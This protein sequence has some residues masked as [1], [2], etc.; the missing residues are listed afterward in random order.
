MLIKHKSYW[1]VRALSY[2]VN[3]RGFTFFR[4]SNGWEMERGSEMKCLSAWIVTDQGTRPRSKY[5]G[6]EESSC[7]PISINGNSYV[8]NCS[9][10]TVGLLTP[11]F[12]SYLTSSQA[13]NS[14]SMGIN[15][16]GLVTVIVCQFCYHSRLFIGLLFPPLPLC[17]LFSTQQ[18]NDTVRI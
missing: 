12:L 6:L 4:T 14:T 17:F 16:P 15:Q 13:V 10:Q 18:L 1:V 7:F 5:Q 3:A 11:F 2:K 8:Y 9:D